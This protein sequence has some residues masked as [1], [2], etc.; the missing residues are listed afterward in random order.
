ME[1]YW[2]AA[3][4]RLDQTGDHWQHSSPIS[5]L[6][7]A[8]QLSRGGFLNCGTLAFTNIFLHYLVWTQSRLGIV[9]LTM[10]F[11]QHARDRSH[12]FF[13]P[14]VRRTDRAARIEQSVRHWGGRI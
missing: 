13:K 2:N 1:T 7:L 10:P 8:D 6:N 14:S 11:A 5:L 12:V 9:F 4:I 3:G